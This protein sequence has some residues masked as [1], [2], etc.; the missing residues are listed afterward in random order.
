MERI[1]NYY[2]WALAAFLVIASLGLV[3]IPV[4]ASV[5]PVT[6]YEG[7]GL[8]RTPVGSTPGHTEPCGNAI[9][10]RKQ[11]TSYTSSA[12][13]FVSPGCRQAVSDR[14]ITT[15]SLA[16]LAGVGTGVAVQRRDTQSKQGA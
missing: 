14:R 16:L 15:L 13:T 11:R 2:A 6:Q 7:H 5:P 8:N 12:L 4:S 10:P 3:V 9:S 1:P